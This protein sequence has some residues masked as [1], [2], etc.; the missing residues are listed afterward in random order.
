MYNNIRLLTPKDNLLLKFNRVAL[1]K[2]AHDAGMYQRAYHVRD[3]GTVFIHYIPPIPFCLTLNFLTK[4]E[5]IFLSI[6]KSK[7]F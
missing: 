5:G 1:L 2:T 7:T 4:V 3:V 6:F